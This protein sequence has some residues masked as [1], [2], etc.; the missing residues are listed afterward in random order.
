MQTRSQLAIVDRAAYFFAL[1]EL[2]VQ[3]GEPTL[4]LI[5]LSNDWP[6]SERGTGKVGVPARS[7]RE[8]GRHVP[9][10]C[11]F[12]SSSG[13]P[14]TCAAERVGLRRQNEVLVPY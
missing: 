3:F 2:L 10:D 14:P 12:P 1:C 11:L 9:D 4:N 7:W 5:D 8:D 6:Q 13:L